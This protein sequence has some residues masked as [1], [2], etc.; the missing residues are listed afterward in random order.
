M[1]R[2]LVTFSLIH[3]KKNLQ[4]QADSMTQKCH[5][6]EDLEA[7]E[8]KEKEQYFAFWA[9]LRVASYMRTHFPELSFSNSP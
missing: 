9:W 8:G 3:R 1:Q 2:H 5:K 6:S 4:S 7:S